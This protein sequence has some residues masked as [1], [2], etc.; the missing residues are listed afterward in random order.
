M[1][2]TMIAR[3]VRLAQAS[4]PTTSIA[5]LVGVNLI[6]LAGVLVWG[7]NIATLL[8]LYWIENGIVGVLNVPK[9]LLARG[10]SAPAAPIPSA[11]RLA[12]DGPAARV[13]LV[14]FFLA[15]YGIFWLVHGVF[16]LTLTTFAGQMVE[17]SFPGPAFPPDVL[18]GQVDALG[19]AVAAGPDLSAVAWGALA[20]AISHGTSF[21][22]N[23][24]GRREYLAVSPLRQMA[25]PYGRVVILHLA[26]LL[27]AFVSLAIGSPIGAVIVLVILKTAVDLALH[28]REHDGVAARPR[29][30]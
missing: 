27:G 29:P 2:A 4:S 8:V 26:I 14:L 13:G 9:M 7:W 20:L 21:V 24:L 18:P 28:V 19:R 10:D 22:V 23:F 16:V 1:I 5:L 6:P 12:G 17:P 15:H 30:A 3:A 25:A 11:N